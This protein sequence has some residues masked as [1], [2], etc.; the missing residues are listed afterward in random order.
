[1]F[2]LYGFGIYFMKYIKN[3]KLVNLIVVLVVFVSYILFVLRSYLHNGWSDW[4]FQNTLPV[5]NVSP[6]MFGSLFVYFLIPKRFKKYYLLLISLLSI[7]MFLSPTFGC[8]YNATISYKFHFHFLVD[9]ICH[10]ILS[11]WGVYIIRTN[12]V[13][14]NKKDSVVASSLIV[15]VAFI[16]LILNLIFNTTFFGLSLNGNHTIY[17]MVIVSN[18]Y[19]SAFLYFCGLCVV[20]LAGYFYQKSFKKIPKL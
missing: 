13:E 7:G 10:F 15:V 11:W 17:N 19:L 14:L 5:A 4:N 3:T 9:Y 16:M 1:M 18:S 6:F 2:V 12:Q 20:L 8:I